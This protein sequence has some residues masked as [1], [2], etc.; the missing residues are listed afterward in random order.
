MSEIREDP[1]CLTLSEDMMDARDFKA[2]EAIKLDRTEELPKSFSLGKR[3]RTTNYQNGR[4][5]CTANSTSHGV[6]VLAVKKK[7][8]VPTKDNIVTPDRKNLRTNMW[9]DLWNKNDSWDYVEKAVST[10]LKSWISTLENDIAK[11]DGYSYGERAVDDKSIETMKRYLYKGCPIERCLRWNQQTWNEISAW[12]L[13]TFIPVEKR[14]WWHAVCLVGWDEWGF[15]FVN[16]WKT[17]D[18]KGYKSRFYVTYGDLKNCSGMFNWRY[19]ILYNLEDAN[20]DP[21]YLKRK[22]NALEALKSLKKLYPEETPQVQR[23]I[24]SLS[25]E[26]RRHYPEINEELP[27]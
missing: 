11:Y 21:G 22:A 10:A 1:W 23:V 18:G 17:N 14:T 3:I 2:E 19:R 13:R 20:K 12:Q 24:E 9:H 27:L 16:S 15:R 8:I 7:G 5:S 6:Q 26:L 25:V 4:G